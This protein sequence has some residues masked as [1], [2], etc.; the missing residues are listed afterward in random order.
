MKQ[1]TFNTSL[2]ILSLVLLLSCKKNTEDLKNQS[3]KEDETFNFV[4]QLPEFPGGPAAMTK[5][6]NDNMRYPEEAKL[7]KVAGTVVIQFVVTKE[8]KIS[9][10]TLT[11]GI[12]YGCDEE[13]LRV[14][15]SMPD[16]KPGKY[17]NK[18]V[19]VNFTLPVKF[20]L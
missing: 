6:I 5:F 10:V 1:L 19:P 7:H 11:R 8:G 14:I 4:E 2:I 17:K 20:K 3:V 16:W 12:G 18:E 15:Q 13:A 9:N